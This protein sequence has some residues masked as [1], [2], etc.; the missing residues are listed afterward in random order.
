MPLPLD[1]ILSLSENK[2][3]V[4]VATIKYARA[5]SQEHNDA[6]EITVAGNR[7]EKLTL[8]AMREVLSGNIE[9]IFDDKKGKTSK[10]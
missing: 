4:T 7:T 2:Y 6:T 1:E 5:L 8:L 3:E 10:K 9:Y